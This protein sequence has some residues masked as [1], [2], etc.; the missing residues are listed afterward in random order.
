[1]E[2]QQW[3]FSPSLVLVLSTEILLVNAFFFTIGTQ[4]WEW[5][6]PSKIFNNFETSLNNT[7]FDFDICINLAMMP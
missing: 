7:F 3:Q 2:K 4:Q 1:M 6:L 5:P